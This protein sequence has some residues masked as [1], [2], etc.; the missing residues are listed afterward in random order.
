MKAIRK[1]DGKIIEVEEWIGSSDVIYSTPDM[2]EF[3]QSSDLD[4]NLPSEQESAVIEGW[5]AR[6]SNGE[7]F[8][9][10]DMPYKDRT[11]WQNASL[12]AMK[13]DAALFPS[14]TWKSEPLKVKIQITPME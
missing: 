5:V 11:Y 10:G 1:S 9:H 3:Y 7:I 6:D 12:T 2:N 14:V 8:L 4:F 13:I